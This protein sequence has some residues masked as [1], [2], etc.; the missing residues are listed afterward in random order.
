MKK[1][2]SFRAKIDIIGI[3]PFVLIPENVLA[4]VF[5]QA[6]KS[7]GAIPVIMT[8]DGHAFPQNLVKYAGDWRLYLNQPMRTAAGKELGATATFTVEFDPS[9]RSIPMHPLLKKALNG[10]KAAKEKFEALPP[11][12]QKEIVRYIASL[13]TEESVVRN[14]GRALGF[15][16]GK[17]RFVGR[18]PN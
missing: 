12:R 8:I 13:K 4:S 2:L 9:D 5:E 3:N 7:K 17:E 18:D 11:S 16:T 15:L 10:N 1:Q 6:G 14:I